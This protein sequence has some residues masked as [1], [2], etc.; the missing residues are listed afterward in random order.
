ME[1]KTLPISWSIIMAV[2]LLTASCGQ[3]REFMTEF[4]HVSPFH[5][6]VP[7]PKPDYSKLDSWASLPNEKD[8][9]DLVPSSK[10]QDKQASAQ[11]DVFFIHPSTRPYDEE[12]WTVSIDDK[13]TRFKLDSLILKHQASIFN[14]SGKIYAPR[15]R[16]TYPK[17]I[18]YPDKGGEQ[19]IRLA[20]SD[21]SDAFQYYL[22]NFNKG[23]PIIIAGHS[24][25]SMHGYFLLRE[26][27]DGKPLQ[28]QL[29]SA[30]LPGFPILEDSLK[31]LRPC[32]NSY[33][34]GCYVTWS[35]FAEGF[36]T[37]LYDEAFKGTV[38]VN[39]I[40]WKRDNMPSV[41]KDH[42]FFLGKNYKPIFRHSLT[43]RVHD[44]ILWVKKENPVL[45]LFYK[46]KNYHIADY[47]LFW[48]N[49]RKNAEL[50]VTKYIDSEKNRAVEYQNVTAPKDL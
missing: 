47:N 35:S 34:I 27:F 46:W 8:Y 32:D 9:A 33:E 22:D 39:P 5:E 13:E 15:Y 3:V 36:Y 11:A 50:R 26:F 37:E 29:V 6:F 43:A 30:Y 21:V 45:R 18:H 4:E 20:Y 14:S 16:Q 44:G 24:Q 10:L 28:S 49:V 40:T 41:A 12:G 17:A 19:A 1:N 48:M 38:C 23:R 25:G 2:A 7:P 42:Y 31:H